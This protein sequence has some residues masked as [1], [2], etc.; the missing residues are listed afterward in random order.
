[1][2][3]TNGGPLVEE[4]ELKPTTFLR[5]E[6]SDGVVVH[7]FRSE[8]N[9]NRENTR[10]HSFS[11]GYRGHQVHAWV[12]IYIYKR[13]SASESISATNTITRPPTFTRS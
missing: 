3:G 12:Y 8:K 6:M 13:R 1:M 10:L 2:G 7:L 5:P 11:K 4:I 9:Q